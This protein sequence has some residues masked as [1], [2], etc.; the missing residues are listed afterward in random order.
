MKDK[1]SEKYLDNLLDSVTDTDPN[2]KKRKNSFRDIFLDDDDSESGTDDDFLRTFEA[3]LE[4]DSYK[5]YLT[6]FERELEQERGDEL[7]LSTDTSGIPDDIGSILKGIE[8]N[9][10]EAEA[11]PGMPDSMVSGPEDILSEEGIVEV[12]DAD[13]KPLI[14]EPDGEQLPGVSELKMTD[15]GEVDLSGGD[16]D[17]L[18]NILANSGE[19]E[20]IGEILN[21]S[22]AA[23]PEGGLDEFEKFAMEQMDQRAASK[24]EKTPESAGDDSE[25]KGKKKKGKKKKDSS[26]GEK[27]SFGEKF[28]R[29]L[30]GEDEEE[31]EASGE[32]GG[33]SE[34]NA[35][36]IKEIDEEE[37]AKKAKKD[38]KK[39]EKKAKAEKQK[40]APKPKKPPKPKKEKPPKEKDNTPPL[41]KGPVIMIV[42]MVAS[43]AVLVMLGT[44]LLNYSSVVT[45][46]KA[47]YTAQNYTESF[48]LLQG[49][50]IQKKDQELYN[51]LSTLAAV[52]SE[53]DSFLVFRNA[54][55]EDVALDSLICSAGRYNLNLE[56]AA[57]YGCQDE[58]NA[59]GDKIASALTE[60]YGISMDEAIGMYNQ[61]NR[62]EYTIL[63]QRKLRELGLE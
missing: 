14:P 36:I 5:D 62:T 63:L 27:L 29:I 31:E 61:R 40:K 24:G 47:A 39:K 30:F 51:K 54:G 19:F 26:D 45:Q 4:S 33:M 53:Y 50:S 35:K 43:L 49:E 59:L 55:Q 60:G 15:A 28:K 18:M 48:K 21:D 12:D 44:N 20:D 16:G 7:E 13:Q 10:V 32:T 22:G 46:A 56:S 6:A 8:D 41:P 58:L 42:I 3:E 37:K 1:S 57:E 34:E 2:S 52:S 11:I 9:S 17:D 23:A 38:K 25:G